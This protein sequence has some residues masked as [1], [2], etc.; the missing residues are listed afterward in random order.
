MV[1][2]LSKFG[3]EEY[4]LKLV[5]NFVRDYGGL[6]TMLG[7]HTQEEVSYIRKIGAEIGAKMR[8]VAVRRME[9]EVELGCKVFL[10]S[11]QLSV[12]REQEMRKERNARREEEEIISM[13][14]G[15]RTGTGVESASV[16]D[17]LDEL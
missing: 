12:M 2:K 3:G 16:V 9:D 1:K 8:E 10:V 11:S 6:E 15:E 14:G 4:E 5:D 7:V 17:K 13:T